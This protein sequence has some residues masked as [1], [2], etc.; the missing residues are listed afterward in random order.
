[1]MVSGSRDDPRAAFAGPVPT[2]DCSVPSWDWEGGNC[3]GLEGLWHQETVANVPGMTGDMLAF[4]VEGS[5]G[6]SDLNDCTYETGIEESGRVTSPS[7]T[8]TNGAVLSFKTARE[9]EQTCNT[10]VDVTI[11]RYST[12]NGA[13]YLPL[14]LE[15][16]GS[17][18][19]GGQAFDTVRQG[20]ICGN[21]L[22]AQTVRVKLPPGT[23]NIAFDFSTGDFANNDFA[24]QFIDDVVVSACGAPACPTQTP[25]DTPTF[26]VTPTFTATATHTHTPTPT[27]TPTITPTP[28]DTPK[29]PPPTKMPP[30]PHSPEAAASLSLDTDCDSSTD[31]AFEPQSSDNSTFLVCVFGDVPSI[32]GYNLRVE[33]DSAK[34]A[35]DDSLTPADY[36]SFVEACSPPLGA[37]LNPLTTGTGFLVVHVEGAANA[38]CP[39]Q[40][41]LSQLAFSCIFDEEG[42]NHGGTNITLTGPGVDTYLID[43]GG[44]DIKPSLRSG[45]VF[46]LDP[47][48][49]SDNDGC[50]NGQELGTDETTGGLRNPMYR[51][52]YYDVLGPGAALPTDGFI[53]LPNDIL[54]VILHFS[55]TGYAPNT[56]SIVGN[57]TYETFDRG[58]QIG[59]NVWNM[60]P[61][62][63]VIDL[64]NDILGVILQAGHRCQ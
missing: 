34:L 62:D 9:Q 16:T 49:D 8:A 10:N 12:D 55:P 20:H 54:S 30:T 44:P 37:V 11:V 59:A 46:C 47:T 36:D 15:A 40:A 24:G 56:P 48:V 27:Q 45:V 42:N 22:T 51:W 43:T 2:P 60:S 41:L 18:S 35:F 19:A 31:E 58:P 3:F 52:D 63:G 7:F 53:D 4:N 23:T 14:D 61:P 26:T 25:T 1:M 57:T 28:T 50:T 21:D 39:A 13:S 5:C 64:P 29:G 33:W 38:T 32:S 17:I 6:A